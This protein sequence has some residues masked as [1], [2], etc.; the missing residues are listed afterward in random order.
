MFLWM[1]NSLILGFIKE[2][3]QNYVIASIFRFIWSSLTRCREIVVL[4]VKQCQCLEFFI[5]FS[6]TNDFIAMIFL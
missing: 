2:L 6:L 3:C 5:K 4:G 1:K